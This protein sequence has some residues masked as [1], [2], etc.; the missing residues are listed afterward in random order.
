MDY[1]N[2]LVVYFSVSMLTSCLHEVFPKRWDPVIKKRHEKISQIC[3]N[4][5]ISQSKPKGVIKRLPV[6]PT[7]CLGSDT[8]TGFQ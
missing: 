6:K 8:R 7:V 4:C 3:A 2:C 5:S 1:F